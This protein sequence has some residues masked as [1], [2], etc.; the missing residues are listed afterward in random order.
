MWLLSQSE[1]VWET[2][3][4]PKCVYDWHINE[5]NA[6]LASVGTVAGVFHGELRR[7]R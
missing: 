1:A 5:I 3:C 6:L 2:P 7:R 4:L